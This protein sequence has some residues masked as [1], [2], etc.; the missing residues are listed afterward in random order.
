M[1]AFVVD[2]SVA[3]AWYL[4]EAFSEAAR[5]YRT[6]FLEGEV[7]LLVPSLHYWE[8]GNVLRTY[9]RRRELDAGLAREV[10][11]LH[12]E[13]SLETAEPARAAVL[14]TALELDATVYD[15]VYIALARSAQATLL[16]AER[17]TTPWLVRLGKAVE[18]VRP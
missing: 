8:F 6:R 15:A 16:T 3:V 10:F 13:A 18:V 2:A 12:L 4:P 14:A 9:I 1:K 11:D 17:S 5:S 7:R